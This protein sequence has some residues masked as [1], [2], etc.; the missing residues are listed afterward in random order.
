MKLIFDVV[1]VAAA[2]NEQAEKGLIFGTIHH[3]PG[4]Q[5]ANACDPA[6]N[7]ISISNAYLVD[8]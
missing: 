4:Y 7:L 6:K 8:E 3:G 1:D 2:K 5:F